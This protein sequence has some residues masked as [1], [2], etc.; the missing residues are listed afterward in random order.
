MSKMGFTE[1]Q[2]KAI[3][4]DGTNILVSAGAGSGKTAV[5][6]ERIL[7]KLKRKVSLE[8]LIILTFTN[9][10]AFE[11]KERVKKKIEEEAKENKYLIKELSKVDNALICTFDSFALYLVKKYHYLL[12]IEK[13]IQIADSILINEEQ[14]KQIEEIFQEKYEKKDAPFLKMIDTFSIKDDKKLKDVIINLYQKLD[15][16][17]NKKEFLETYFNVYHTK[18]KIEEY[19][20]EYEKKLEENYKEILLYID[21]MS[22]YISED[23]KVFYEKLSAAFKMIPKVPSYDDFTYLTSIKLPIFRA[24]EDVLYKEEIKKI[25]EKIKETFTKLKEKLIYKN[26]EEIKEEV[27]STKETVETI[28]HILK[29]LEEKM[30]NFKLANKLFTFSDITL[31][32]ITILEE[33]PN[34]RKEIKEKTKEIMIDEYQDTNDTN[35]YFISLIANNNLYMVGDVKQSIYGF[36]NANP[37]L[38]IE[39]YEDYKK[40]KNGI[41]IDLT[42]NFRSK[43]EVLDTVN[44]IFEKIMDLQIG[45]ADYKN[46][47]QMIA[48]NKTQ[49][50][51]EEIDHHLEILDYSYIDSPYR[52]EEIEAFLI[53]QD[54]KAKIKKKYHIFDRHENKQR[55]V[56]FSDFT[57]LIDRKT[58]FDLYK[59]VFTYL[60]IPISINREEK[61]IASD[62]IYVLKNI[63][64]VLSIYINHNY[65]DNYFTHPF[66]SIARSFLFSYNDTQLLKVIKKAKEENITLYKAVNETETFKDFCIKMKTVYEKISELSLSNLLYEIYIT[67]DFYNKINTK[68]NV[69]FLISKLDYLLEV[70]RN[71]E[72]MGYGLE[73]MITYFEEAIKYKNDVAFQMQKEKEDG[74]GLTNIHKSKGLEYPI[75]YYSGLYKT[76]S[77]EEFKDKF[78]FHKKYGFIVPIFKE[79]IKETILKTLLKE[80]YIKQDKSEKIRLFYVALTRAREKIILVTNLGDSEKEEREE[81]MIPNN[82]RLSYNSFYH[83]LE[84]V[85]KD[86]KPYIKKVNIEEIGITSSY[87]QNENTVFYEK[88]PKTEKSL[89]FIDID[90]EKKPKEK[91]KYATLPGIINKETKLKIE[92]GLRLH[93]YLEIV[94]FT[95]VEEEFIKYQIPLFYQKQIKKFLEN[96]IIKNHL[97]D[98]MYKEYHFFD[99]KRQKEGI[100][101]LLIE[102]KDTFLIIDYK[103]KEIEKESYQ[104]QVKG[105]IEYIE[106]ITDKKVEGYLYSLLDGTYKKVSKKALAHS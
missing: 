23:T 83:I 102:T 105:Y 3:F 41:K 53:G 86:L 31:L 2:K 55:P 71:L 84:S 92:E 6:T 16:V 62:E 33:N 99:E 26:K 43:K 24:K 42:D 39:K 90:I 60:N 57:I 78:S 8:E 65:Y 18:E 25:Y 68:E 91:K 82:I 49:N 93:S 73:E 46:G 29:E 87:H 56:N 11:M 44:T 103:L 85:K 104:S 95:K 1:N 79:G 30:W 32:A 69:Y 48:G 64:K 22:H 100:I 98:S 58:D 61:F 9:A 80:E 19:I 74:V 50:T 67:F 70:A 59:K 101:D 40:G 12:Q 28:I 76:F 5:L 54:I 66:M 81:Q 36:R 15:T 75:C 10:A 37:S 94:D 88:I 77:K 17:V 96:E 45:G 20:K 52:K 63:L 35:A 34:I 38:F 21:D 89:S 97:M 72:K 47:H 51:K 4:E 106:S 27:N 7:E 14:R 13:D